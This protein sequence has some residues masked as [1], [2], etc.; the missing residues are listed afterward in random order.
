VVVVVGVIEVRVCTVVDVSK[1][2]LIDDWVINRYKGSIGKTS[3][4]VTAGGVLGSIMVTVVEDFIPVVWV[5]RLVDAMVDVVL[6]VLVRG[7]RET[8]LLHALEI[9]LAA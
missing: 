3:S 2:V 9:L 7:S 5:R 6:M 8:T 1:K 4:V